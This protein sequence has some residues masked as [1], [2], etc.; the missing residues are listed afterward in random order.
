MTGGGS[1]PTSGHHEVELGKLKEPNA[2]RGIKL[3]VTFAN[4]LAG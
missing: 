4:G 3:T 1:H 2:G